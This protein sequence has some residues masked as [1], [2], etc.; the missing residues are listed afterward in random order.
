LEEALVYRI[1]PVNFSP[2]VEVSACYVESEGKILFLKRVSGKSEGDKWGIPGGKIEEGETDREAVIRETQEETRIELSQEKLK[3][4]GKFFVRKKT[5]DYVF[6]AYHKEFTYLPEVILNEEHTEYRWLPIEDISSIPTMSG[7]IELFQHFKALKNVPKIPRKPFYFIRH[8][9][10]DANIN[11]DTKLVDDNLPLNDIGKSQAEVVRKTIEKHPFKSV[12]FSP[13]QRAVE[14]KDILI[15]KRNIEQVELED[16]SE[17][18][19]DVWTKMVKFEEGSGYQVCHKVERFLE[20]TMHGLSKALESASPPLIVAH[21]G[22][23]WSICYHLSIEDHPWK[24]GN[25]ELVYVQPIG[26]AG[27][28]MELV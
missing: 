21:G 16:L 27:W 4:I 18:R 3:F 19:E 14:T 5:I 28:K 6:Y 13:I 2:A 7:G 20:R 12:Y 8:G 25:C 17:C 1:K 11:H 15:N 10:T 9:Q 26:D 23:H 22:F 24:I